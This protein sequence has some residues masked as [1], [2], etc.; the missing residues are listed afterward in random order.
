MFERARAVPAEL[1]GAL[2]IDGP[3]VNLIRQRDEGFVLRLDWRVDSAPDGAVLVGLGGRAFDMGPELRAV[4]PGKPLVTRIPLRCFHAAGADLAAV[5][6]P[7]RI[8][9]GKG[10]A[11]SL[12]AA[13]VEALGMTLACSGEK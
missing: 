9:A 1:A 4:A 7:L 2:T 10:L 13:G 5:A 8:E 12:G 11:L 3:P 6:S